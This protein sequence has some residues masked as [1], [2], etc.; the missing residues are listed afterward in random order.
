MWHGTRPIRLET[1]K[2]MLSDP[3]ES[4]EFIR[5]VSNRFELIGHFKYIRGVKRNRERCFGPVISLAVEQAR[6]LFVEPW[7]QR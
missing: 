2:G 3:D 5:L 6:N 4:T 1:E 7:H